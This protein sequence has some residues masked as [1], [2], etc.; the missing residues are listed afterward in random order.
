MAE[1][2][3]EIAESVCT[4]ARGA[5]G[6]IVEA[7]QR[8]FGLSPEVTVESAGAFDPAAEE[9]GG[10]GLA[11][12]LKVGTNAALLALPEAS[13]LLPEWYAEPDATGVSKLSTLAQELGMVLLPDEFMP[14]DFQAARVENLSVA[15]TQ[16]GVEAGASLVPLVLRAD[17]NAGRLLLVWPAAKPDD[18][19]QA[20]GAESAQTEPAA[21]SSAAA[22]TGATLDRPTASAPGRRIKYDTID[23]G[24]RQL[25][26]YARS[27]L[28]IEVPVVVTLAATKQPVSRI[29]E[30]GPG[31]II[32][33]DKSCE[34][35]LSLEVGGQ[36]VAVGEAVK[37]GDK[38][39]L[40][41][42][43]MIMPEER[44][45]TVR[46]VGGIEKAVGR[47]G[48]SPRPRS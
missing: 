36:E 37:V 15:L 32:Q 10:P 46:G 23:D 48:T 41:L 13:G 1:F 17:D 14:E 19:L 24:L 25:P 40:R 38:F 31:S 6:E 44:F 43:S 20:G 45:W 34:E 2:S 5:V 18:V 35:T 28:R 39:G 22:A 4:T 9:L 16:G 27:I 29:V 3:P 33:F 12:V 7:F 42:T 8:A 26:N 47:K 11:I 30:L 21:A